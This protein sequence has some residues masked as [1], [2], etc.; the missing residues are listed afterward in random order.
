M[1][2]PHWNGGPFHEHDGQAAPGT[3]GTTAPDALEFESRHDL[4]QGACGNP[5]GKTKPRDL[6]RQTSQAYPGVR[7]PKK[8]KTTAG[9][10]TLTVAALR[11]D[12]RAQF[13]EPLLQNIGNPRVCQSRENRPEAMLLGSRL[14]SFGATAIGG[15][16]DGRVVISGNA[17]QELGPPHSMLSD[18]VTLG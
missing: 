9:E 1:R 13:T 7:N 2:K 14:H 15:W 17:Q 16:T 18:W 4:R 8:L 10:K 6:Q 12:S 5:R 11:D 3:I